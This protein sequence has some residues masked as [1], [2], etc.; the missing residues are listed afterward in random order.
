[1]TIVRTLL[2][3]LFVIAG[4]LTT[5]QT[6][7]MDMSNRQECEGIRG[8]ALLACAWIG[9][10][11]GGIIATIHEQAQPQHTITSIR[12]AQ[13]A[14]RTTGLAVGAGLSYIFLPPC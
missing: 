5:S 8:A 1:M 9:Q 13:L 7:P 2:C 3:A 12:E 4:I 10:S 6:C 14:G 11:L